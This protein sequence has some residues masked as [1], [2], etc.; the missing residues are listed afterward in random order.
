MPQGPQETRFW[1]TNMVGWHDFTVDEVKLATGMTP[2]AIEAGLAEWRI[3]PGMRPAR[4]A[5]EDIQ[6]Q[7][8]PGGR[9]PRIGFLDGAIDPQRET[10]FS[11]FLP[12]EGAGYAVVD[13]P[14]A[15]WSNLGLTYLAHRH[16]PTIWEKQGVAMKPMEWERL[17]HG[18]R[19]KRTLPN[20]IEFQTKIEPGAQRV[21]M[22]L[23]MKN[24]SDK[25]LKDLR[26]QNCVML[27]M[28]RGFEPQDNANKL[29]QKPY[30]ACS[31]KEGDRWII[32][33]WGDCDRMWANAPC[34]C[35]HSDPKFPDCGPGESRTLRGGLWFYEG[36]D[37][38]GE[39]K[40][41][42][43]EDWRTAKMKF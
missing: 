41:L 37:I 42:E 23:S 32:T 10:K 8:Y 29:L 33:A 2:Q 26:V 17:E 18:L 20:G 40:R 11:V 19:L 12:W 38:K 7:P 9:H 14:E 34:P 30:A 28:A 4:K 35:M 3:K 6:I 39:L 31:N 24:G 21:L 16:I 43:G 25:G 5:G 15:I 27:K 36:R 22:E 1:L 13:V